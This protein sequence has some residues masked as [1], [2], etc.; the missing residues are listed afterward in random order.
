MLNME[1]C[2]IKH[3]ASGQCRKFIALISALDRRQ[4]FTSAT[5]HR[6][7][8]TFFIGDTNLHIFNH[9]NP[10]PCQR[11]IDAV[12]DFDFMIF[13]LML[14]RA[15]QLTPNCYRFCFQC[16]WYKYGICLPEIAPYI[17]HC[18]M[19]V[20]NSANI[21]ANICHI[22]EAEI[23]LHCYLQWKCNEYC[24]ITSISDKAR[25]LINNNV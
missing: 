9:T 11:R 21:V 15:P 7:N 12:F 17:W 22:C 5:R 25:K 19:A 6:K 16:H 2:T 24:V 14:S 8:L 18:S 3:F 1:P 20:C 4:A 23:Y 13:T 10:I